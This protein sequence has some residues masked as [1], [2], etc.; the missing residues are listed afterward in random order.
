MNERIA[1]LSGGLLEGG[2]LCVDLNQV[3]DNRALA[4]V[5]FVMT[6]SGHII[7]VQGTGEQEP[8]SW[9][10]FVQLKEMTTPQL[11]Q[12]FAAGRAE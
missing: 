6:E 1:A 5:N 9:E 8:L 2:H 7:E 11:Q 12:L 3:E 10:H 4:D